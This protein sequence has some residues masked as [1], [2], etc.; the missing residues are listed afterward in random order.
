MFFV[1][2]QPV[3]STGVFDK[4]QIIDADTYRSLQNVRMF[5]YDLVVLSY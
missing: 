4:F 2:T 5:N 1:F 3:G